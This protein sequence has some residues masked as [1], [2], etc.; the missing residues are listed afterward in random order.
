MTS[1]LK[2]L[3]LCNAVDDTAGNAHQLVNKIKRIY[4]NRFPDHP[5]LMVKGLYCKRAIEKKGIKDLV[6]L[7]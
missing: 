6:E 1:K 5:P 7:Q 3:R 2:S 4:T